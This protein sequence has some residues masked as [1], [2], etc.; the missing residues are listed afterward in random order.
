[1]KADQKVSMLAFFSI[2]GQQDP[3]MLRP[4]GRQSPAVLLYCST[5]ILLDHSM[6]CIY[7]GQGL[8]PHT[9]L[10][11]DLDM[12]NYWT[13]VTHQKRIGEK[14]P[15]TDPDDNDITCSQRK[16]TTLRTTLLRW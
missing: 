11:K 5:A 8:T 10:C 13:W 6:V 7:A 12:D 2:T 1:M 4:E 15:R 16:E 3:P 9:L 14:R